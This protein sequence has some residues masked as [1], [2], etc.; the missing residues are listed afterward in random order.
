MTIWRTITIPAV[1]ALL[2]GAISGCSD[3]ASDRPEI[4]VMLF[5][6]AVPYYAPMI[7][8][9]RTQADV[10]GF[11]LDMQDGQTDPAKEIAIIQ[12]FT[13]ARKD[14]IIVDP[15]IPDAVVPAINAAVDAGIPV[16]TLNLD[17][18]ADARRLAYVGP[19]PIDQGRK[20]GEA[21]LATGG[22]TAR[23]AV[24]L[25]ALGNTS[26]LSRSEGLQQVLDQNPGMTLLDQQT[27]NWDN[28]Q[29]LK[30]GQDFLAKY[31]PGTI[32]VI[33]GQGPETV[34]A[35]N[36]AAANG[37]TDVK[38]VICDVSREVATAIDNG[39]VAAGVYTD[40][41][42]QGT[43][44]MDFAGLITDGK[45]ADVPQPAWYAPASVV[46][47]ETVGGIGAGSLF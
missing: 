13:T 25:G 20:M 3:G 5:S 12:Q 4:G 24:I 37:R 36:W 39:T 27:A 38:F 47:R 15:S 45:A 23:V 9:L 14:V 28:G 40:P 1:L 16:L 34:A 2:A 42:V 19:D 26:Q 17:A 30:V 46:D 8:G 33:A 44:V 6:N 7:E 10:H 41:Y 18:G 43:K 31:P 11:D 35:A 21:V 29:A 32:D 22:P